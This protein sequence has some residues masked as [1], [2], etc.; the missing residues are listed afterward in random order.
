MNKFVVSGIVVVVALLV[1]GY[2]SGYALFFKG[3]EKESLSSTIEIDQLYLSL[4]VSQKR[5]TRSY[6]G[7]FEA[8]PGFFV[9][10]L[11]YEVLPNTKVISPTIGTVSLERYFNNADKIKINS[12]DYDFFVVLRNSIIEVENGAQI[13]AAMPLAEVFNF[14]VPGASTNIVLF[15]RNN[16]NGEYI[17]ASTHPSVIYVYTP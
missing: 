4:P 17:N 11:F 16:T 5:L 2:F 9:P 14:N 15:I 8:E 7:E 10:A 12:G 13:G 1:G 3:G 6:A